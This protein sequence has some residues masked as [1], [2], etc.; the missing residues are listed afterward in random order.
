LPATP[1]YLLR[2]MIL[3]P[4]NGYELKVRPKFHPKS[5]PRFSK[6][7]DNQFVIKSYVP[8]YFLRKL[9]TLR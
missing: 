9:I 6:F 5:G 4:G 8:K 7:N 3:L 1:P 2:N